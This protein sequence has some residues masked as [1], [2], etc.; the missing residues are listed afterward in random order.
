MT[1]RAPPALMPF[2]TLAMLAGGLGAACAQTISI[3]IGTQDT[4]TNTVT[5]GVVIREL[6][7]LEKYLPKDGSI[8][9]L[10]KVAAVCVG[11]IS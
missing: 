8:S 9:A 6:K 7:L 2:M 10:Q 5:T 4:T 11:L 3:G 1:L